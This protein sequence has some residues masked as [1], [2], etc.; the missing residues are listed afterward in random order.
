MQGQ[1]LERQR[2]GRSDQKHTLRRVCGRRRNA[3]TLHLSR[4]SSES[5][6]GECARLPERTPPLGDVNIGSCWKGRSCSDTA[7]SH[8]AGCSDSLENLWVDEQRLAVPHNNTPS[9]GLLGG[10]G[11]EGAMSCQPFGKQRQRIRAPK[12]RKLKGWTCRQRDYGQTRTY[13]ARPWLLRCVPM[14][15]SHQT[16]EKAGSNLCA[17][18]GDVCQQESSLRSVETVSL[19]RQLAPS[20]AARQG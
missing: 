18:C 17:C 11:R 2:N 6:E 10:W 7:D 3:W 5:L 1:A 9:G 8:R 13:D 20:E 16:H 15:W 14:R 4:G 12:A 19:R